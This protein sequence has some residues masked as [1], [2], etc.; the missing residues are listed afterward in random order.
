VT[1]CTML[2]HQGSYAQAMSA[3]IDILV[4]RDYIDV[5]LPIPSYLLFD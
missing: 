1:A 3:S 4:D 2:W 5:L